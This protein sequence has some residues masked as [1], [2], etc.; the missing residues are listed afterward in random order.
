MIVSKMPPGAKMSLSLDV[1]GMFH[2]PEYN[3]GVFHESSIE[4]L[5]KLT[6][7]LGLRYDYSHVKAQYETNALAAMDVT[8]FG[9]N[10]KGS[11]NMILDN[12][13]SDDY[14]R[15]LPKFGLTYKLDKHG[16]NIY[17]SVSKGFRAG[18]FNIQMFSD[19]LQTKVMENAKMAMSGDV[20]IEFKPEE[21]EAVNKT[22][23]YKPE[24]STNFEVGTHLDLFGHKL[25][26]D[27]SVYY[28]TVRNMQLSVMAGNYGFG[29]MMVNAGKSY[30]T[31]T[32]I[33][34]SGSAFSGHLEWMA[35]YGFTYAKFKEYDAAEGVSYKDNKVPYVPSHTAG[36][37]VAYRFDFHNSDIKS[38]KISADVNAAGKTW[39]DAANTYSQ[40]FY[41]LL[42][43]RAEINMGSVTA[44]LW[45]KNLTKTDY[46]TFAVGSAAAGSMKYFA[47]CGRP[48]Q[49]GVDIKFNL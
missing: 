1:P 23:S 48:L 21:Y 33:S 15:L 24:E 14:G 42:G 38:L 39:W 4:V 31:G 18:G 7:T 19:I 16:S 11:V 36:G 35:N 10:K 44:A 2:T 17:A 34:L 30:S 28:M 9:M 45:G 13:T 22:I 41:A 47:Q 37:V 12:A 5:P 26:A 6:A 25:R 3:I 43:A 32:E 40:K 46:N 49:V 20:E 8:V 29:R 27:M